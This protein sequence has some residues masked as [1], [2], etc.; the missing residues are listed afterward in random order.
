MRTALVS[1]YDQTY[2]SLAA[3]T[4]DGTR[5]KY[6][7]RN[8]YD[9]LVKTS[10]FS[11]RHPLLG[12][13]KIRYLLEILNGGDYDAVWWGGADVSITNHCIPISTFIYEG[14][15]VTI[16]GD[17]NAMN[18]DSFVVRNTPEG[19]GW[20]EMIMSNLDRYRDHHWQEQQ[21]MI[22]TYPEWKQTVKYLPQRFMNSYHYGFYRDLSGIDEH[23]CKGEWQKGD[24]ALHTP[25]IH[26][27]RRI[28]AHNEITQSIVE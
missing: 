11:Y 7:A 19:K 1:L 6:A 9:L 23:G 16:S 28:K 24:F 26:L 15:H 5:K 25:A 21:A 18:S 20:L 22:D 27:R 2:A 17:S 3:I 14:Y 10:G 12:F 8:G 4:I 13:E